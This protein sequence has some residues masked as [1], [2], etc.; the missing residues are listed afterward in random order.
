M[1]KTNS[2]EA[3]KS[4]NALYEKFHAATTIPETFA[5]KLSSPLLLSVSDAWLSS[6]HRVVIIGKEVLGWAFEQGRYYEW[7]YLP[8]RDF[9][10]FKGHSNAVEELVYAYRA[11]EF[12]KHQSENYHGCFWTAYR[13][14]RAELEGD[15]EG[16]VLWTNLFRMS[17]GGWGPVPL[18]CNPEELKLLQEKQFGL[19]E[20]EISI[21]GPNAVIFFTGPNYDEALSHEF[22]GTKF[23]SMGSRPTRKL[24]MISHPKLPHCSVRTYH[25]SYLR[26]AGLWAILDEL[27]QLVRIT[28]VHSVPDGNV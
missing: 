27:I 17:V 25:P 11:F 3:Q 21:L 22:P 15:V 19:L 14:L 12:S 13:K 8:L 4:L 5:A 7:P 26:R 24:A 1:G 18:R 16:S 6:S 10:D 23:E 9:N 20:K 2:Q 28:A